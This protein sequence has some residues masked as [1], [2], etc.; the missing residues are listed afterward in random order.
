[1]ICGDNLTYGWVYGCVNGW[2][3]PLT[4][5][6]FLNHLSLLQGYFSTCFHHIWNLKIWNICTQIVTEPIQKIV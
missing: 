1:M 4:F 6:D 2:F 5:F 3:I